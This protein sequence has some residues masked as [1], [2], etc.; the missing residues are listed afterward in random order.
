MVASRVGRAGCASRTRRL[1]RAEHL[2]ASGSLTPWRSLSQH[3]P[4][5][6]PGSSQVDLQEFAQRLRDNRDEVSVVRIRYASTWRARRGGCSGGPD[7]RACP[8]A[9][10][11]DVGRD[12]RAALRPGLPARAPADRQPRRRRGPDPGGLRPGVPQS[13]H[14]H[15]RHLRGLA[16]PDHHQ[17]LPRPGPAQA[18][19][20]LRCAVRRARGAARPARHPRPETAVRRADLRRRR[21]ARAR[22]S[23]AGLP[24]RRRAVRRR[25]AE[26]RGDRHDPRRQA[27]HR[28]L[29]HPPR[30]VDAARR[31]GPPGAD[32][33]V[34]CATPGP[35]ER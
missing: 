33:R 10:G 19:D 2:R 23:A 13:R 8:V 9:R 29:P 4:G 27:R 18:A 11:S 5:A 20:P 6:F 32:A 30:P 1:Y 24:R 31:A 3:R 16:A 15:A 26:L 21:R 35:R 17:P 25:G 22:L 14:L 34:G 28:P 12:R 7:G